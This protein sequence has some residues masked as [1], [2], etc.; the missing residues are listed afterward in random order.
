MESLL[1]GELLGSQRLQNALIGIKEEKQC[2]EIT[3]NKHD[4]CN[5]KK[6]LDTT[7]PQPK[8]RH[9]HRAVAIKDL[10]IIFGGGNEGIVDELHVFN[11]VNNQWFVP[12]VKGEIPPGCAAYGLIV[13]G[14]RILVFGGMV[15]FGKYSNELYELQASRWEWKRLKPKPP[16]NGMLPCPRLG[17]SFTLV[18]TKVFL[19]GGLANDGDNPKNNIPRYLNDLY[20]L[21]LRTN[22]A[23]AWEMP[24]TYGQAPQPRES[25]TCVAYTD[26]TTGKSRLI[27][28]GGMC[29]WRLGDIWMLDVQSMS[30]SKPIIS[31]IP[32]LP[33]SLHSSILIGKRMIIFGGWVPL[34]TDSIKVGT[35]EKEWKCTNTSACLNV[36]TMQWEPM[37]M[38]TNE[39]KLPR[40][41][42][43]HCAVAIHSRMYIWSGRDCYRK[44]CCKDLWYLD[45]EKPPAPGR[46]QLVKAS[47]TSLEV[48][49]ACTAGTEAYFLQIQKYDVPPPTPETPVA[50]PADKSAAT[51]QPSTVTP[52][53]PVTKPITPA[54]AV[55][56]ATSIT[57]AKGM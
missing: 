15:E 36:E 2:N 31:G 42:A 50:P 39:E 3:E 11:T 26:S 35:L 38:D 33:R 52:A 40:A 27:I 41:R 57:P 12:E 9:G 29:G 55:K 19:F 53:S 17:H 37:I 47:T 21:E 4:K 43:G 23:V 20:T 44:V 34:S 32:P 16:K 14:T 54:V 18:G 13:D 45:V 48:T 49:W 56:L 24:K 22:N 51:P 6:I 7:G 5:W 46:V 25:H 1:Q 10:M 30:W 8:P 28:Y